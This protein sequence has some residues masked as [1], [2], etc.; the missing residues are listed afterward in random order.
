MNGE[1]RA[2]FCDFKSAAYGDI[3]DCMAKKGT[4]PERL[5]YLE[6]FRDFLKKL[7][8]AEIGET[9]NTELLEELVRKRLRNKS[10]KEARKILTEDLNELE[11]YLSSPSRQND[12]LHFVLG[13]FLI[14]AEKP[15]QFLKPK[16]KP[17]EI[18]ERLAMS[19]PPKAKS[20]MDNYSLTAKWKRQ[21]FYVLRLDMDDPFSRKYTLAQLKHPDASEFEIL[22]LIGCDGLAEVVPKTARQIRPSKVPVTLGEV[23]GHKEVSLA[24][25]PMIGRGVEYLLKI[26]GGCVSVSIWSRQPFDESEWEPYLATLR[27]E[28]PTQRRKAAKT[29]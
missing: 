9:T 28:T 24:Q 15:N 10:V 1:I 27:F 19:L 3:S 13:F 22:K 17:K 29:R 20:S 18:L 6:S 2:P 25:P 12:R 16:E 23:F 5:S 8:R 21:D 11:N 26:P 4:L 14:A 7:P